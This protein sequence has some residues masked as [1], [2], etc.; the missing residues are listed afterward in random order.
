[1]SPRLRRTS[2]KAK[3]YVEPDI[4]LPSEVLPLH[5]VLVPGGTFI[6]GSPEDESGRRDNEGPQHAVTVSSFFMGRYPVTQAQWRAVVALPKAERNLAENPS[7]FKGDNHPVDSVSWY[8]AVEFCQRLAQHTKLP[9]RLPSEAEWEY[10]CRAG[11]QTPFYFGDTIANN[12]S[13][14]NSNYTYGDGRK[15]DYREATT[16]VNEFG[17]ANVFGLSDM[18][19]N[20]WEWCEDLWHNSYQNAPT[21]GRGWIAAKDSDNRVLRG[22]SCLNNPKNCRSAFRDN[23]SPDVHDLNNGFRLACSSPRILQ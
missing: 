9:Y 23:H 21:D 2:R 3:G 7:N 15:S 22:G 13:N 14:Y 8:D 18:H 19:G 12:L 20:V 4:S 11:T 17:I 16:L 1:M 6:M 10:A 5:M